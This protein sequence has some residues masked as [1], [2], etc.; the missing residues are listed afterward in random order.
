[1]PMDL[2]SAVVS[3]EFYFMTLSIFHT[4]CPVKTRNNYDLIPDHR[5]RDFSQPTCDQGSGLIKASERA[6]TT[7]IIN[8]LSVATL[9]FL[10]PDPIT[11]S[12]VSRKFMQLDQGSV[13]P[14]RLLHRHL[15]MCQHYWSQDLQVT[16]DWVYF[17]HR[18]RDQFWFS[19][20]ANIC[21]FTFNQKLSLL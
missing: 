3:R 13:L 7:Y 11:T 1:M 5:G 2:G 20:G 8:P 16:R 18:S 19:N 12:F 6:D 15:L 17:T 14:F 4:D 10:I 9:Q 21:C